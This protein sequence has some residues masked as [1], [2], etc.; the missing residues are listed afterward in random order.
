MIQVYVGVT[1][2]RCGRD[3]E[4]L[5]AKRK[6]E[7]ESAKPAGKLPPDAELDVLACLW[8]RGGATARQIREMMTSYR[9][10]AHGSTVTLLNRLQ[11]RGF[12]SR[13]KG[14]V[15]KAFVY[16]PTESA[17]PTRRRICRDLVR[18]VFGGNGVEMVSTLMD[19]TP[20]SDEDLDR[21]QEMLDELRGRAAGDKP[22]P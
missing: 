2:K 12:V 15:G 5:L 10:M 8:Q 20:P 16:Q 22:N 1:V 18:R 6:Q 21:L 14:P 17:R 4:T 7:S 3:E 11:A 13:E 9:P 19:A